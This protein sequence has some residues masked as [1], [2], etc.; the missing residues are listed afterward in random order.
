VKSI[1]KNALGQQP[2]GLSPFPPAPPSPH[3]NIR[4]IEYF[5]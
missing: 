2:L 3:D 1:L 4:G 5:E